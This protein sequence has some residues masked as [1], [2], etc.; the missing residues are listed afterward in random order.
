LEAQI[1]IWITQ[2]E[3]TWLDVISTFAGEL[4]SDTFLPSHDPA[5][6][7]RVWNI[8]KEL[9]NEVSRWNPFLDYALVEGILIAALFH[10]LGMAESTRED[11]GKLGRSLCESWFNSPHRIA[12]ELFSEILDAIEMHDIKDKAIYASIQPEQKPEILSILSIADDLE[13]LGCIGIYRYAEIYLERGIPLAE[14]GKRILENAGRRYRTL[15]NCC[16]YLGAIIRKYEQQY[17]ELK[18][19]F[20][21]Y[22]HQVEYVPNPEKVFKGQL[23]VINYIRTLG[24]QEQL[25]PEELYDRIR[26][27]TS[28]PAINNY[29]RTLMYELDRARL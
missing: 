29:F 15:I 11:H 1:K 17:S 4:F 5:H 10:D 26:D 25:R 12:P 28:D 13:A 22:N 2:V 21:H 7:Q 14:L 27:R 18:L 6:H 23:G 9:L 3:N 16:G 20:E 24:I 19:F 8:S